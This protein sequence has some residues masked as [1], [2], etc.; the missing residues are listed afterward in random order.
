MKRLSLLS[1]LVVVLILPRP[2]MAQRVPHEGGAAVGGDIGIFF[3]A[4]EFLNSTLM[5]DGFFEYYVTSRVSVR[6]GIGWVNP[7]FEVDDQDTLRQIPLTADIIYNWEKREWHPFVG[8]GF[9]AY[10]LQAKDDG[11]S[12]GDSDTQPGARILGGIEYFPDDKFS[13]K[14]EARYDFIGDTRGSVN[15]SGFSLSIGVKKYF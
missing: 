7:S 15:P 5:L 13:I 1:A 9:G 6:G 2:V 4:E 14:G 3:P 10:F 12:V 8:A 11:D